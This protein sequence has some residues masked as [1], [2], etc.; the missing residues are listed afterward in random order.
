MFATGT[1]E[2][3]PSLPSLFSPSY[4]WPEGKGESSDAQTLRRSLA[5]P[6]EYSPRE[7]PAGRRA[8]AD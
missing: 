5:G 7:V 8:W 4:G 1:L 3:W 6:L 2:N